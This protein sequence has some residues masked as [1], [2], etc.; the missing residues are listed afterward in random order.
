MCYFIFYILLYFT[1]SV[2][3]LNYN[4]LYLCYENYSTATKC[5]LQ[6][7]TILHLG[8]LECF[9]ISRYITVVNSF[10]VFQ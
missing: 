7:D 5:D 10:S 9:P 6:Q 1:V 8:R 2:I 4:K 3:L